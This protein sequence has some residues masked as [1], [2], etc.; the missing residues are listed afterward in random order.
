MLILL[1]I[2]ILNQVK[3]NKLYKIKINLNKGR[4]SGKAPSP[5]TCESARNACLR[6]GLIYKG[7][8]FP[9]DQPKIGHYLALFIWPNVDYHWIRKVFYFK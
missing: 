1:Q 5:I 9:N 8:I 4:Y 7:K 2:H 3:K 6:D